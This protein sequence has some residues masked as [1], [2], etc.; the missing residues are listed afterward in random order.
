M[1]GKTTKESGIWCVIP[2]LLDLILR[3]K[4]RATFVFRKLEKIAKKN[5]EENHSKLGIFGL[6]PKVDLTPTNIV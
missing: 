1:L 3:R 4:S 6:F 5:G 2:N